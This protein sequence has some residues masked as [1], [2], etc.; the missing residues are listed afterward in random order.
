MWYHFFVTVL[1]QGFW[2]KGFYCLDTHRHCSAFDSH[3]FCFVSSGLCTLNAGRG[4]GRKR[5]LCIL[6]GDFQ[7]A[8][9][10]KRPDYS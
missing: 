8:E 7:S 6:Q 10:G 2:E 1:Y 3:F 5:I 9:T 4:G